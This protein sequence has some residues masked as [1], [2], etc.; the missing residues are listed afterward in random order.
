KVQ[1]NDE[2]NSLT[3][4]FVN[5][6]GQAQRDEFLS[7][8]GPF[9][10]KQLG[11]SSVSASDKLAIKDFI[12]KINKYVNKSNANSGP[13]PPKDD[14]D[15]SGITNIM[16]ILVKIFCQ[17]MNVESMDMLQQIQD[18]K[19]TNKFLDQAKKVLEDNIAQ[20]NKKSDGSD[21]PWYDK[22]GLWIAIGVV[23]AVVLI[24]ALTGQ[25]EILAD[26]TSFIEGIADEGANAATDVAADSTGELT[27]G[28][29]NPIEDDGTP[30][31]EGADDVELDD[32]GSSGT[33]AS[34]SS[35]SSTDLNVPENEEE[36]TQT[37]LNDAAKKVGDGESDSSETQAARKAKAWQKSQ[38]FGR[39]NKFR[40]G[41]NKW[42][43][44]VLK[45]G[46]I[47]GLGAG[48]VFG[49]QMIGYQYAPTW[50]VGPAKQE[51]ATELQ[52]FSQ[53]AQ[54]EGTI[55]DQMNNKLQ[56]SSKNEGNDSDKI[57]QFANFVNQAIN[58]FGQSFVTK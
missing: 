38:K 11:K 23:V 53:I 32:F 8:F 30:I 14:F 12:E 9:L 22:K 1:Y 36:A 3:G 18:M 50:F 17:A 55:V 58:M 57:S 44:P 28:L 19:F 6:L 33:D 29:G 39:L 27:D 52:K 47:L 43:T 54:L 24:A 45:I 4:S 10:E 7:K 31:G 15:D 40:V 16:M 42:G 35:S 37:N 41:A 51:N 25:I 20:L 21:K 26:S 5:K 48:A 56:T 13:Q 2:V 46:K 49:S 34:S